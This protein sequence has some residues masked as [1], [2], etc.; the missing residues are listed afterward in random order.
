MNLKAYYC[1][2]CGASVD[3]E[4]GATRVA[5]AY[6][7]STLEVGQRKIV[8][9]MISDTH[10]AE[11]HLDELPPA[12]L[13]STET[14]RFELSVLDQEIPGSLPDGF[15][16]LSLSQG[17]FALVYLRLTDDKE[18]TRAA[19]LTPVREV[20][21]E[22]LEDEEDPGMAA[23]AALESLCQGAFDGRLEVAITLFSPQRCSVTAYN[24]GCRSALWW[25]SS[26]EGRCID[27]FRFNP[28]LER[29]MLRQDQDNFS[30]S[31]PCYLAA[32]DLVV[33]ASAAYSGRG[34]GSYS[35]GTGSLLRSLNEHLGEHPLR[36]VTL[37]KNRFWEE[38]NRSA[39]E[40]RLSG[41]I[42]VAAVRAMAPQADDPSP[43]PGE[44]RS[45]S[46]PGFELSVLEAPGQSL[47]LC[48]L[49]DERYCLIWTEGLT[50]ADVAS[51]EEA[52]LEV[53]DRPNHGD[54]ENPREAGRQGLARI[55]CSAPLL[56][57][58]LFPRW[59]R[60][61]WFRAGWQQPL[62]LGPRGFRDAASAQFFDGGGEASVYDRSRLYFPGALPIKEHAPG[63]AEL[64]QRWVG[65]KASALYGALFAHWRT[66]KTERALEKLLRAARADQPEVAM[67]GSAL[68]TRRE[69]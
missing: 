18:R 21:R 28:A 68:L 67:A 47:R 25:V 65:G 43:L 15:F 9:V 46:V 35:D 11:H 29:K 69:E 63:G 27:I 3:P 12:A 26:E 41:P 34:G 40:Q 54:N 42:R 6:C 5:C 19:D 23:Y 20:L 66:S 52:V 61:K 55:G 39:R 22:H 17:R 37:A 56:V 10:A 62:C 51:L 49:H 7:G 60:A 57:L 31:P 36:V 32:G 50:A 24:A 59:G 14:G 38:L 45:F 8:Q 44:I 4:V 48:P 30:N 33:M 64:A 13:W 16:P 58:Q 1:P 53:L 2:G